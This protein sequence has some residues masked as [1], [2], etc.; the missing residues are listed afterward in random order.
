MA[1]Y[2]NGIGSMSAQVFSPRRTDSTL[3]PIQGN[4]CTVSEPNYTDLIPPMQLR[5]MSK[6]VRMGIATAKSA[7]LDAQLEKPDR[8]TLGTA[9]GCLADTSSFLQKLLTQ[10]ESML[11]PTAFIQSTHNTVSGQIAL[12]LSCYGH[13]FTFVHRGHSFESSLQEA[14]MMLSEAGETPMSILC[15]GID[16]L[17]Q[18]SFDIISRFGTYKNEGAHIHEISEG[19]VAGEGANLLVLSNASSATT[20]AKL[21]GMHFF[22]K[23]HVNDELEKFLQQYQTTPQEIDICLTGSNGDSRYDKLITEQLAICHQAMQLPYKQFCGEYPTAS[24]FGLALGAHMIY[25][26]QAPLNTAS[27]PNNNFSKILVHAHYKNMFHSF[28]LLSRC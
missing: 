18:D 24:A 26:Q 13:N 25:H 9:Y 6:V 7:L 19:T 10:E 27:A 14:I 2:I 11:S 28:M 17:T 1:I 4:R 5:R 15:G 3:T 8:I 22:N 16:E 12:L 20:Y 21:D 23:G